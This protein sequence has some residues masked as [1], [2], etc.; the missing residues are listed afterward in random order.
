MARGNIAKD[1]VTKQIKA[2]FG[3]NFVAEVDKKLYVWADD[4]G[5]RVQIAIS[6]T[7]PK[8]FVEPTGQV[9]VQEKDN[10][11]DFEAEPVPVVKVAATPSAEISEEE[12]NN[13]ELL[14]KKLGL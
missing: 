11:F 5:E 12:K 8:T 1:K 13:I 7:C 3:E 6:L 10:G 14:M 4:G 9:I 2:A